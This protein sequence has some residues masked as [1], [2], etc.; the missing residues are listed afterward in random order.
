MSTMPVQQWVYRGRLDRVID[1][2]SLVVWL[3]LGLGVHLGRGNEGAHL[4]LLGVDT[5]ER[6]EPGWDE[7]KRFTANW[8]VQA[9]SYS[10]PLEWPL[11]IRTVKADNFGRYLADVFR[12]SDGA[13]LN[14]DLLASGLATPYQ[15]A[16]SPVE[17]RRTT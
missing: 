5:P 2:D 14:A 11:V 4:R 3:D 7:A 9:T 16:A 17:I 6:N 8:L 15:A 1:G 12:V 10:E 13:H